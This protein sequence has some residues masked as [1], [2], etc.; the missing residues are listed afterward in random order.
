MGHYFPDLRRQLP[1]YYFP[2]LRRQLPELLVFHLL[3][4]L[5]QLPLPLKNL[6]LSSYDWCMLR[7]GVDVNVESLLL[8]TKQILTVDDSSI[9]LRIYNN[10]PVEWTQTDEAL[11]YL[12]VSFNGLRGE[13]PSGGVFANITAQSFIR[14]KA[15]RDQDFYGLA[16]L[17]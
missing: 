9:E 17:L 12:N 4:D 16:Y 15:L 14:D 1:G 10:L 3:P 7:I 5:H 11:G 13:I 6:T 8:V 2:D